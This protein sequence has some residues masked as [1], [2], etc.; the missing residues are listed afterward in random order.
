MYDP[1]LMR[2]QLHIREILTPEHPPYIVQPG[3][4]LVKTSFPQT[5]YANA[6]RSQ[7]L[8][9]AARRHSVPEGNLTRCSEGQTPAQTL[10]N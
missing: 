5:L 8:M 7:T 10:H 3:A 6:V 2:D 4:I 9:Y 1:M